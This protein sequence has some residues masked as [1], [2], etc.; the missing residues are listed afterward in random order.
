MMKFY[1]LIIGTLITLTLL[2]IS[3]GPP[4]KIDFDESRRCIPHS[5]T[6]DTATSRFARIAWNPGCPGTRVMR[7]FNIYLSPVPLADKYPGRDL[8]ESIPPFNDKT[9]PGDTIGDPN[10]ETYACEE[11]ENAT[12]YYAHVRAIYNDN[13]LSEPTNEIEVIAYPQ[14]EIDLGVSF[15]GD[16]DG[17]SFAGDSYCRTDDLENDVYFYHKDGKDYLCSP[18]RLGPVNRTTRI[19]IDGESTSLGEVS[20][21]SPRGEYA[22]RVELRLHGIYILTTEEGYPAKLWVKE[23]TGTG[24]QRRIICEY[25]FRPPVKRP[26]DVSS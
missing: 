14:G 15:S 22:E 23:I 2:P 10:R 1:S 3:C 7:G 24:D 6:L 11:I 21:I 8:P 20:E 18:S 26:E 19:Y 16:N 17:F 4:S 13:S 25:L 12:V 5:L 9:Y